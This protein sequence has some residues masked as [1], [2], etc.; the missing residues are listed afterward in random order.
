MKFLL[1]ILIN[2]FLANQLFAQ[3]YLA[4][5][6]PSIGHKNRLR[7]YPGNDITIKLSYSKFREITIDR[8]SDSS[9]FSGADEYLLKD[10]KKIKYTREGSLRTQARYI[11]PAAGL[12]F[13]LADTFNPALAR[14]EKA[15]VGPWGL[16]VGGSMMGVGIILNLTA[17]RK[18]KINNNRSLKVLR[19]F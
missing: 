6:K 10:I 2:I 14:H 13:F 18:Y 17:K 11:L 12:I 4:L 15:E 8:L 3:R 5:D 19:S 16:K 1:I 7:F 9:I